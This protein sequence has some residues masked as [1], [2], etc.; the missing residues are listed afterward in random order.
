[1]T[2]ASTILGK[3]FVVVCAP[4][5]LLLLHWLR[6]IALLRLSW[7]SGNLSFYRYY[8][9]VPYS[10][11]LSAG[12]GANHHDVP[13]HYRVSVQGLATNPTSF[14][15]STLLFGTTLNSLPGASGTRTPVTYPRFEATDNDL[16]FEFRIG[17]SGAGDSWL[18]L[19]SSTSHSRSQVGRY[20]QGNNNN[21]YING[22]IETS[23]TWRETPDVVTNRD[24][25]Y[26]HST[27]KGKTWRSNR[28][29]TEQCFGLCRGILNQ[30][31]QVSDPPEWE[32]TD[33]TYRW[34]H[35][36]RSSTALTALT[37][38]GLRGKLAIAPTGDLIALIP[39]NSN[40]ALSIFYSTA[41]G[42]FK[43]WK[44]LWTATGFDTEPLYG[45]ARL[46]DHN[47]LS[48]FV[49]TYEPYP[50]RRFAGY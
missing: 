44:R 25:G 49:R 11:L 16:F 42:S 34:Y 12:S 22:K 21:A 6:C 35:Y 28:R 15:R 40:T 43:G 38:T 23:R 17:A 5:K 9:L 39:S 37:A 47:V 46:R 1:M 26:A 18:Y 31:G 48:V 30:E 29:H 50:A 19:Y 27:D 13:F 36:W 41:A 33:G 3:R 8:K 7:S 20:L 2:T 14:T 4:A 45:K 10:L 24:L 32:T